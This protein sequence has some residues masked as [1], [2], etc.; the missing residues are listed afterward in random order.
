VRRTPKPPP[1][2]GRSH[3]GGIFGDCRGKG[4]PSSGPVKKPDENKRGDPPRRSH[5]GRPGRA[6][7][8]KS[9]WAEGAARG[10]SSM[11]APKNPSSRRALRSGRPRAEIFPDRVGGISKPGDWAGFFG[12]GWAAGE[13][14]ENSTLRL[15]RG[16]S[17][18]SGS[19]SGEKGGGHRWDSVSTGGGLGGDGGG[20][21]GGGMGYRG[22]GDQRMLIRAGGGG[23]DTPFFRP[24][25]RPAGGHWG[26]PQRG[27][28]AG[29]LIARPERGGNA[30]GPGFC[31]PRAK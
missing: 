11:V 30:D 22:K 9:I 12:G 16:R 20:S 7:F 8:R 27:A 3:S 18:G 24:P 10:D 1:Q 31:S 28:L 26:N 4:N 5:L 6:F 21:A 15:G 23:G 2:G 25:N 13:A 17:S 29:T 19:V 14:I